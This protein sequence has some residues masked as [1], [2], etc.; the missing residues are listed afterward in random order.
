MSTA[1]LPA[2]DL[3]QLNFDTCERL[4]HL[5]RLLK[6]LGV[7]GNALVLD[8]GGYPCYM[9]RAFP[10]WN[11]VTIDTYGKGHPPYIK[12]SG[13]ALPF[14]DGTFAATVACDVLEHVPPQ[15][16]E[17]FLKELARVTASFVIVAGPYD[18]P[19]AARAE[20]LVKE[21]LPAS[22]PAQAW[23]AEHEECGLPSL[24]ETRRALG[25]TATGTGVVSAGSLTAWI[26]LFAAQAAGES[27][28]EIDAVV[29]KFIKSYNSVSGESG[30]ACGLGSGDPSYRHA[31]IAAQDAAAALKLAELQE[32]PPADCV[33]PETVMQYVDMLGNLVKLAMPFERTPS[34][35]AGMAE[36]APSIDVEYLGRLE[37]ML[38]D[39]GLDTSAADRPPEVVRPFRQRVKRSIKVLLGRE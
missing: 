36:S 34:G 28:I 39:R 1:D 33:G 17:A 11:I 23:L 4:R 21:L 20:T 7:P 37:R 18:T 6:R 16:R 8:V 31:V 9:A 12:G 26:L 14:K 19:G 3:T 22:S 24:D 25:T 13:A 27:S 30:A 15:Y 29:Q 35:Q 32:R 5:D 10:H 38:A 2:L